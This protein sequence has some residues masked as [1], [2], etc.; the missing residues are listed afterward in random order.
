LR[1]ASSW[2]TAK[3]SGLEKEVTMNVNPFPELGLNLETLRTATQKEYTAVAHSPQQDF[4]VHTG[5]PLAALPDY[6]DVWLECIPERSIAS[7]A[8]TGNAL[9]I[10]EARPGEQVVDAGCGAGIDSLFAANMAG[11]T[12]K[13][14][15]VDILRN[16]VPV[17]V[18]LDA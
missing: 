8:G 17:T 4:H 18:T 12:G 10:T 15:G 5:R 13:V 1:Y 9:G 11:R 6:P 7:F 2:K 16:R 14:I 3:A